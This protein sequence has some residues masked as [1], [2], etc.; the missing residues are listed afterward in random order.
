MSTEPS[1]ARQIVYMCLSTT[2]AL[3][4]AEG[5]VRVA[6]HGALPRLDCYT[7]TETTGAGGIT[8][9]PACDRQLPSL[10]GSYR[11]RVG[12]DGSRPPFVSTDVPPWLVVGDS[13][14]LGLGVAETEIWPVVAQAA[15]CHVMGLG[16]P[17][18]GIADALAG[19]ERNIPL[20]HPQGL[21]VVLNE[22]NDWVENTIPVQERYRVTEGWLMRPEDLQKPL[23]FFFETPLSR[24]HLLVYA[25]Q[26]LGRDL[27]QDLNVQR[28][29]E[30]PWGLSALRPN[31]EQLSPRQEAIN[32]IARALNAFSAQHPDLPMKVLLLPVDFATS[33]ARAK[34]VFSA[35][36]LSHLKVHPWEDNSPWEEFLERVPELSL[37]DARPVLTAPTDFLQGDYH[38]SAAGHQHL[39]TLIAQELQ[40]GH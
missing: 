20:L 19:A 34:E 15:G 31:S 22:A 16:V 27:N 14:V 23:G 36:F 4:A 5:V 9:A 28:L 37:I 11:L 1:F 40:H 10:N 32:K 38:L 24:L 7:L 18:W 6:D 26:I 21:V 13:Q 12:P 25:V 2:L 17:G 3:I 33:E 8:L 39:G 30:S 29:I 35:E